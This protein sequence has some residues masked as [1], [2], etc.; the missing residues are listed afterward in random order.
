MYGADETWLIMADYFWV[1]PI[2]V[3]LNFFVFVHGIAWQQCLC[4]LY[5]CTVLMSY[6]IKK[7]VVGC[8][9]MLHV[10]LLTKMY[11]SIFIYS[12]LTHLK[13]QIVYLVFMSIM[14]MET[15][16][17]NQKNIVVH[18][19]VCRNKFARNVGNFISEYFFFGSRRAFF[20]YS[21]SIWYDGI[22]RIWIF[23]I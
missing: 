1:L 10:D 9:N 18:S 21:H 22:N 13:I 5:A 2:D 14:C 17:R 6:P 19:G 15:L 7:N 8:D 20:I 12:I 23:V 16:C 11:E 3:K 4:V